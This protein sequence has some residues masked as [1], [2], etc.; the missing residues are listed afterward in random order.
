MNMQAH[1]EDF[2]DL[3]KQDSAERTIPVLAGGNLGNPTLKMNLSIKEVVRISQVF[4]AKT[5]KDLGLEGRELDAQRPLY[6]NH[7]KGLAQYVVIGLVAMLINKMKASGEV[8]PKRVLTMQEQIGVSSYS[9]LQPIV[10][11]IRHCEEDFSDLKPR[12]IREKLPNGAEQDLDGVFR[13]TLASRH[14][15][16]IVD[17]QHR[18]VAFTQVLKWLRQVTSNRQYPVKGLFQP[19][20]TDHGGHNKLHPEMVDFW[21]QVEDVATTE[22][23]VCVECHLGASDEQE[24]QIFSDLNSKGKKAELSLSLEYDEADAV[25]AFIKNTLLAENN[26]IIDFP[27]RTS[28]SKDWHSD[29]GGLLRKE[30]NPITC[31]VM[32]GKL[33]SK[34]FSPKDVSD[35]GSL[36][37]KFWTVVQQIPG[38]GEPSSR[39]KTVAAQ[40]VVLKGLARLAYDLALGSKADQN[41]DHLERLWVAIE[42]GELDFSHKNG[43]WGLLMKSS[44]ERAKLDKDIGNYIH[45]PPGTNLDAGTVDPD[46]GWVRYGNK[47]N[48]IYPRIGDLI[49]WKLKLN[50]RASVTRSIAK[51]KQS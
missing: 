5:I 47:H 13:I 33:S 38:F 4:N 22:S 29:D 14:T 50:P 31:L 9:M 21:Q 10:A 1:T 44:A 49:R 32:R 51:E 30:L 46:H 42:S 45:V 8:V 39:S 41:H 12:A 43:M 35:Y 20:D 48:D 15:L 16:S 19:V 25:N 24:R 3:R 18:V 6:E 17:G 34:G 28:D 26:G 7:A 23:M 40:P 36:A 37:K 27:V 11:N 2:V